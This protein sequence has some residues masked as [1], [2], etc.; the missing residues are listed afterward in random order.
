MLSLLGVQVCQEMFHLH[1]VAMPTGLHAEARVIIALLA[2]ICFSRAISSSIFRYLFD[3]F[4]F[5]TPP[6]HS[7]LVFFSA[8]DSI[9]WCRS[10][11]PLLLAR[12][13]FCLRQPCSGGIK[14]SLLLDGRGLRES[15]LMVRFFNPTGGAIRMVTA[16]EWCS[17]GVRGVLCL[18]DV[19]ALM[20]GV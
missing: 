14:A 13:I 8:L 20:Y 6:L 19:L 17:E 10:P 9:S 4:F 5:F 12:V 7:L 11:P 16:L 1:P 18:G 15:L 2:L 3:F